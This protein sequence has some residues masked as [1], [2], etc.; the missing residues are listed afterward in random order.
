[1]LHCFSSSEELAFKAIDLGLYI[2]IS[3]IVTFKNANILQDIVK[4]LPLDKLLVE[5]DAP[6][7]A[8][9]PMRGKRN[10]PAFTRFVVEK[11]AELKLL[12]PGDVAEQ[13]SKNFATLFQKARVSNG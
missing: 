8:P 1:M 13:T 3:G 11:I 6:Y 9:I 2:S 4:K 10:E 7:L 12:S 5:T